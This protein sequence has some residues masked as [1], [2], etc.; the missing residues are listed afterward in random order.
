MLR[1]ISALLI[2]IVLFAFGVLGCDK[3]AKETSKAPIIQ[4]FNSSSGGSTA[5]PNDVIQVTV[6]FTDPDISGTPNPAEFTFKWTAK[7]VEPA[8]PDFDPND[9]FLINDKVTCYWRTPDVLGFYQL[10]VEVADRYGKSVIGNYIVEISHNRS[11]VI[12][13][14]DV[15]DPLPKQNQEV[16]ITVNASDPDGNIP[17]TY[18]WSAS[19]G[20]FTQETDNQVVWVGLDAKSY[21]ITIKV[22]DSLGA[23]VQKTISINVQGNN[24]PIIDGYTIENS[25]PVTGEAVH[26]TVSAHDPDGDELSYLWEATGGSFSIMDGDNATWIAPQTV[27]NY[28]ITIK[29][30]DINHGQDSV[31]IPVEVITQ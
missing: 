24:V 2:T 25:R 22:T 12:A 28:S 29:V 19:G 17:L 27:G 16:S 11:P 31:V 14:I 15:S 8:N 26:I 30:T 1:I 6:V 23:Y 3:T 10:I 5:A 13:S 18:D 21:L 9:N 7:A 4:S 20:Y